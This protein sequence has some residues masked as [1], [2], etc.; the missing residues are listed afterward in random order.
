MRYITAIFFVC[1][2]LFGFLAYY[3]HERA[4][5]YQELWKNGRA[6][7]NLLITQRRKEYEATLAIHRR[8]QELE[9]A[10]KMDK[11]FD[12]NVDISDSS[13]IKRLQAN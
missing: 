3:F 5:S 12:W 13:V 8:N 11:S 7:I 6:N 2:V 4:N 1:S 10:A 9:Q